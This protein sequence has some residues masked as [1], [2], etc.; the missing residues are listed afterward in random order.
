MNLTNDQEVLQSVVKKAW[1]DPVFKSSLI[2]NP[3]A[4]M[5]DF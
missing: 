4:T 3:V 2:R 1:K 5:E